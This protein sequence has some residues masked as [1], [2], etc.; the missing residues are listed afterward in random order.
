MPRPPHPVGMSDPALCLSKVLNS[1]TCEDECTGA[2]GPSHLG[3]W[4]STTLSQARKDL[5]QSVGAP[6]PSHLGTWESADSAP[7]KNGPSLVPNLAPGLYLVATPIG[8][9][10]DIT[11]RALHVL[12]SVDR[13]ACEDTRQTQKLLNH[14]QISA[15]TISCHEHNEDARARELVEIAQGREPALR[16]CLMREC[17][18]SAIRAAVSSR[19]PL[20]LASQ[21]YPFPAQMRPSA[22]WSP[23]A[24]LPTSLRSSDF[25]LKN[26]ARAEPGSRSWPPELQARRVQP[27][28][29]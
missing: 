7:A 2:P 22:R 10:S 13:I 18:A 24:C 8:N 25:C 11:L 28:A 3:T 14:F 20:K 16:W 19:R 17:R 6:G 9:L 29:R 23:Q 26:P 1:K 5:P 27:G 12:R 15:P 21:S 4:E